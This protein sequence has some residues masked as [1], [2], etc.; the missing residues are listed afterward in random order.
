M[1]ISRRKR[2]KPRE[3]ETIIKVPNSV[4]DVDLSCDL[5]WRTRFVSVIIY[6][7]KK[8]WQKN[9]ISGGKWNHKEHI[10][11]IRSFYRRTNVSLSY[12]CSPLQYEILVQTQPT[13]QD[14]RMTTATNLKVYATDSAATSDS[15]LWSNTRQERL[16]LRQL[17]R[18]E[19][20]VG[21]LNTMTQASHR[22]WLNSK[23]RLVLLSLN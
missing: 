10:C 14:D 12:V 2:K 19:S 13:T 9:R 23:D 6:S 15:F 8:N 17:I 5:L 1:T 18:R 4:Q 16:R 3:R 7:W 11:K 21:S 20:C 22:T